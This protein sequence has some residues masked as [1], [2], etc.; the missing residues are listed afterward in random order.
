MFEQL[1]YVLYL[2]LALYI[3]FVIIKIL[4]IDWLID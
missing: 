2:D 1:I 3:S 4:L